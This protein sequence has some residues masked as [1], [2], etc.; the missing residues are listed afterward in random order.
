[1]NVLCIHFVF[2]YL[3]MYI[4]MYMYIQ[5]YITIKCAYQ[6]KHATFIVWYFSVGAGFYYIPKIV[7]GWRGWWKLIDLCV[8]DPSVEL[9]ANSNSS[10]LEI[11]WSSTYLCVCVCVSFMYTGKCGLSP[12]YRLVNLNSELLCNPILTV[13]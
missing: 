4:H 6:H 13:K 5:L 3:Y 8:V 10:F 9:Q 1:M 11:L 7:R 2:I 12:Q